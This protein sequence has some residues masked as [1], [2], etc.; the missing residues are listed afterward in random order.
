M[1][2]SPFDLSHQNQN[3]DS[4]IIAS[5]E[6]ISQAFRVMLWDQGKMLGL[7]PIQI[8][9]L[10][11]VLNHSG[12]KCKVS[13][14]ADEFNMTRATISDTIKTLQGKR[15]IN[16]VPEA[17]DHRSYSIQLT[18]AGKD[19][20]ENTSR[21]AVKLQ[22]AISKIENG[23]KENLLLSL[24]E[25]IDQLN[26]TGVISRQRMCFTCTYYAKKG[27]YQHHYC[28]LLEQSLEV[29]DL[30]IDCPEHVQL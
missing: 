23:D 7:S 26:K 8:Q 24:I 22:D 28:N 20:A 19:I 9:L 30:R 14:L 3:M 15:L 18:I 16:K 1:N 6:R 21:F 17:H 29:R 13:Y 12:E 4:K 11:F 2:K 5:L 27:K 25:I 10:I